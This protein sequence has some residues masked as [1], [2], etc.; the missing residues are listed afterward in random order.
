MKLLSFQMS[1]KNAIFLIVNFFLKNQ[2]KGRT[3]LRNISRSDVHLF[4]E[5]FEFKVV[6]SFVHDLLK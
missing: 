5:A 6:R 2:T 1:M 3:S 4:Q